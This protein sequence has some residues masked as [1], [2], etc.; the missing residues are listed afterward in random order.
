VRQ[1]TAAVSQQNSG[2]AQIFTAI[3]DMSR[4]MDQSL[5]RLESTQ[6]AAGTLQQVSDQVNQLVRQYRVE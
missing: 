1:I 2:F 3:A 5:E 4:S 6:E